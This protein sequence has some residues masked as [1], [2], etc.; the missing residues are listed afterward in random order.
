MIG[1]AFIDGINRLN[2]IYNPEPPPNG[3]LYH[4]TDFAGLQGI[5]ESHKLRA[6]YNRVLNDASEQVHAERVLREELRLLNASPEPEVISFGKRK[7]FVACF[8]ESDKLLSMWRAYAGNGGGY[9]LGFDYSCMKHH[10]CWPD[11]KV[12]QSFPLLVPVHYGNTPE[13]IRRYLDAVCR[14]E[15]GTGDLPS[16]LSPFFPSMIKHEA[17]KEEREWRIIALDP[18]VEQMKFRPGSANIRPFVELSWL[19][20]GKPRGK[21]PLASITFGP[22]LRPE[23]RPEEIIGWMLEKNG[24][25]GVAVRPSDIPFRL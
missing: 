14:S 25:T 9:C 12:G 20:L 11:P 1:D 3:I 15:S 23:D 7:H 17:F 24:Y 8:C 22:T 13:S 16:A 5:L 6:T 10:I 4:Y 2:A 18:P 19:Y 21:L